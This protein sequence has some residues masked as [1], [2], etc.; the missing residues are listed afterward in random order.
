MVWI[1][2]VTGVC[3]REWVIL[4]YRWRWG[5]GQPRIAVI[6]VIARDRRDRGKSVEVR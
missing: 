3:A 2:F 5:W 6:A 4:N 1:G